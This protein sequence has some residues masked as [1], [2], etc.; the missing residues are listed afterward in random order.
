MKND[1]FSWK[2]VKTWHCSPYKGL[3]KPQIPTEIRT[4]WW[5]P[6]SPY[7]LALWRC[8]GCYG[9]WLR[10][11]A[12]LQGSHSKHQTTLLITLYIF[13]CCKLFRIFLY[14]YFRYFVFYWF[15]I[16][17][18]KQYAASSINCYVCNA[19]DSSSPF[20]CGEWFE[21][22]DRPDIKPQD[23]SNV[24]GAKYCVKHIGR[25]EGKQFWGGKIMVDGTGFFF[26]A[27]NGNWWLMGI[28]GH[29]GANI[30]KHHR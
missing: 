20:Q 26:C 3:R 11:H 22:Y 28:T 2:Q 18:R 12:P 10:F 16:L 13:C 25:F 30:L 23:C 5:C 1:S 14:F 9:V 4:C 21:R 19:T 29:V 7:C 27:T 24:Y 17:K 15:L 6:D 8:I